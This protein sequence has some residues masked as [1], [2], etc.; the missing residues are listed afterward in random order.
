MNGTLG[1]LG[2]RTRR[3]ASVLLMV[4]LAGCAGMAITEVA[5]PVSRAM[6]RSTHDAEFLSRGRNTYLTRCAACHSAQPVRDYSAKA[7]ERIMPG[8][9]RLAKLSPEQSAE[10][11]AYVLAA[12]EGGKN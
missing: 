3:G 6:T 4:G 8:M 10:I 11:R 7:W 5:P 1:Q 9:C 12:A 2:R